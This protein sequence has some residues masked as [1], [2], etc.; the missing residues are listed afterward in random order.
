[1]LTVWGLLTAGPK[2]LMLAVGGSMASL[3]GP[4]LVDG[5]T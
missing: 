3:S 5:F 2:G 1:M 4:V